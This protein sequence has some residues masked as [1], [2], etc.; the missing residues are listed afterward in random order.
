M[1]EIQ[2]TTVQRDEIKKPV[3]ILA[4]KNAATVIRSPTPVTANYQ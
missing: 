3:I 1:D 2:L 4:N